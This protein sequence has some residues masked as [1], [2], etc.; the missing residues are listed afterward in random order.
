MTQEQKLNILN[1]LSPEDPRSFDT[2]CQ[3]IHD[4]DTEVSE[5]AIASLD[6]YPTE[7]TFNIL[8]S[9][10]GKSL[11]DNKI[12]YLFL[13]LRNFYSP[14]LEPFVIKEITRIDKNKNILH[15][16][17]LHLRYFPADFAKKMLRKIIKDCPDNQVIVFAVESL[18]WFNSIDLKNDW[19]NLSSNGHPYIEQIANNAIKQLNNASV[20]PI[21]WSIET[22]DVNASD[23][24][25]LFQ[26]AKA[27]DHTDAIL[28]SARIKKH[29][30]FELLLPSI[31]FENDNLFEKQL[32]QILYLNPGIDEVT[33]DYVANINEQLLTKQYIF[34]IRV[35]NDEFVIAD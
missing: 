3:F 11:Y 12:R 34:K 28:I 21:P 33:F 25:N 2:I 23:L 16:I 24:P 8:L 15:H 29:L 4:S 17:A 32:N 10:L 35:F 14:K 26:L 31:K 27:K 19:I 7:E 30:D 9:E 1:L 6:D 18:T 22:D 13:A 5:N 20:Q